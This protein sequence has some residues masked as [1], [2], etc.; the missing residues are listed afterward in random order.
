MKSFSPPVPTHRML[1]YALLWCCTVVC[2]TNAEFQP[3]KYPHS[4]KIRYN[5]TLPYL[6][7][8]QPGGLNFDVL[9][10]RDVKGQKPR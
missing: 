6:K 2:C 4:Y 3:P 1:L 9:Y 8:V 5:L 7:Q 10:V